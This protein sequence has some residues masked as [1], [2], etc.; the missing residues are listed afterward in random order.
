MSGSIKPPRWVKPFLAA[1][2]RGENVRAAAECVG[3]DFST[4]YQ[5][6]KRHPDFRD[7]W[8][9][10]LKSGAGAGSDND[11]ARHTALTSTPVD[12]LLAR[13]SASGS[14]KIVRAGVGRWSAAREE[15]FLVSLADSANV[16]HAAK[17][18]GISTQALYARR[19]KDRLFRDRWDAT[20]ETGKAR[21]NAYLI[22]AADRTF[23]PESLPVS[24]EGPK[25]SVAEA[26]G[27]LRLKGNQPS[28]GPDCACGEITEEVLAATR[29]SIARKL[30]I[31]HKRLVRERLALGW[32]LDE[33]ETLIP[34]GWV[35]EAEARCV[36]CGGKVST[37]FD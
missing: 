2:A 23:D 16:R 25:V 31:Q 21:L 19:L 7:A 29:E 24:E 22:E 18:A 33:S 37:S 5:R 11:P 6:R 30:D 13:S 3:V 15:T 27:I 28:T 36:A 8:D 35:R 17:V 20:I 9:K 4:A 34:P 32:S 14:A 10:A 12:E 26:V 1:L